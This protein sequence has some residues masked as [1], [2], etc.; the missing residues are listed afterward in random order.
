MSPTNPVDPSMVTPVLLVAL[1]WTGASH[2]L[3]PSTRLLAMTSLA[4]A[5]AGVPADGLAL[6]DPAAAVGDGA[7]EGDAEPL[8][9]RTL[10]VGVAL[11]VGF[12]GPFPH[13][14]V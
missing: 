4:K 14:S 13:P 9:G 10:V 5:G 1:S 7:A 8:A 2:S 6:S 12:P 11:E 3:E